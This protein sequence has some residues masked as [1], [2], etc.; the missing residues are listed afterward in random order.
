MQS[1]CLAALLLAPAA[2]WPQ[3]RGPRRDGVVGDFRPPKTWPKKLKELWTVEVGEG[4]S[5]P[6][7]AGDSIYLHTRQKDEE[8]VLR[9]E[10]A[11]GKV[12]WRSAYAAPYK[13]HPAATGH[14]KGPKATPALSGNLLVTF[15]ISGILTCWDTRTGKEIWEHDLSERFK[16]TSP[17]Y[18]A[19]ASPLIAE[20]RVIVPVGGH[21][22]GAVIAFDLANGAIAWS[23]DLDGPG[24]SSPILT[25]LDGRKQIVLQTQQYVVGLAPADG[26]TVWKTPF[27]TAYDQNSITLLPYKDGLISSGYDRP[28]TRLKLQKKGDAYEVEEAWSRKEHALYLSSPVRKGDRLFGFTHRASGRLFCLDAADGKTLWQ[29]DGRLGDNAALLVAGEYVLA[30]LSEGR[31][32]VLRAD[33]DSYE[34]IADYS[35]SE[36][37][38]WAHPVVLGDRILI[39]DKTTLRCLTWKE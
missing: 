26:K 8:T 36:S 15:G 5:S 20:Q 2:D 27:K 3:W 32:S 33:A 18:G 21:D 24:Y 29:S 31:M 30:L 16:Q 28:L 17:L 39:K 34:P 6:I 10:A 19:A 35:V 25:E 38:T 4:H 7:V 1:L 23:N 37:P 14:G 11:T 22:K 13:M 12:D 9:L